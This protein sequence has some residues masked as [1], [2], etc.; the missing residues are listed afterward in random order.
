MCRYCG[1]RTVFRPL[2]FLLRDQFLSEGLLPCSPSWA[3][4]STHPIYWHRS[5]SCDHVHPAALGGSST[6][7]NNLATACY[8]CQDVKGQWMLDELGWS[9]RAHVETTWDGLTGYY[10]SLVDKL[11][12]YE[13]SPAQSLSSHRAWRGILRSVRER[14]VLPNLLEGKAPTTSELISM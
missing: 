12:S 10:L 1:T 9:L 6:D 11:E 14:Q 7:A 5:T 3:R 13:P 8:R 4:S 2:L